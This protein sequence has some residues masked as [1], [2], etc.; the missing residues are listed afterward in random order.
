VKADDKSKVE[1]ANDPA[2]TYTVTNGSLAGG[3]SFTGALTRAAGETP[4]TYAITQGTLALS[5][6]YT[7]TFVNGTFTITAPRGNC[8]GGN[9]VDA[10][11]PGCAGGGK[12]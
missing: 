8:G 11:T 2:L 12:D 7:M 9:G 3:D 4:G 6:N 5:S 10:N 1:G